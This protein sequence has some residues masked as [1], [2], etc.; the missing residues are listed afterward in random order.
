MNIPRSSKLRINCSWRTMRYPLD[1]LVLHPLF[2]SHFFGSTAAV[3]RQNAKERGAAL[4][5]VVMVIM[6]LTAVGLFAARSTSLVDAAT[7]YGRQAAQTVAL[8]DYG[9][10]IVASELGN[11]RAALVFQIMDQ[12][13]QYCPSYASAG[14]PCYAYDYSQLDSR[15]EQ[16]TNGTD[17]IQYPSLTQEGSLG[18]PFADSTS[19]AGVEGVLTV[20]LYDPFDISNIKGESASKASGREVTIN[21]I[22]QV[23]PYSDVTQLNQL[24]EAW[25]S[26]GPTSTSASLLSVRTQILVPTL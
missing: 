9:T 2:A 10:R 3:T 22:A 12:R 15:V 17:I 19:T 8:A 5:V 1:L 23:R 4:F 16:N 13:N 20:E 18:P 26:N 11:G 14:Q 6:L 21:S 24:N 25:C 7:G